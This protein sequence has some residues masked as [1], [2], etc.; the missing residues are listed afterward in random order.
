MKNYIPLHLHSHFSLLDGLSKPE[1]IRQRIDELEMDGCALTDHGVIAGAIPFLKAMSGKK[2][3]ILGNE[4]YISQ[5]SAKVKEDANRK[6]SHLPLLAKNDAGWK[7][8]V[9]ITSAGNLPEHF[10]YKPR[11]SLEEL[12]EYIDGNI[13]CFSGHLG[14]DIANR[15]LNPDDTV[16]PDAI[17]DASNLARW[18][19]EV[20]GDNF[21]LEVQRMEYATNKAQQI[22]SDIVREV[23]IQTG[24]PCIATPDAHYASQ[25]DAI[26]QRIVLCTGLQTT[27]EKANRPDFLLN[28]FFK[29]NNFHIP[30]Y[31]DMISYGHTEEELDNTLEL[32]DRCITYQQVLRTPSIPHF[33]CPNGLSDVQYLRKICTDGLHRYNIDDQ[34]HRE[35]LEMEFRVLEEANLCSYF[36][37]VRD[38]LQFAQNNGWLVGPGRGSSGGCLVSYTADIVKLDPL[39]YNLLFERFYN[40]SRKGSLPDIDVDVPA[41]KRDLI[42]DYIKNKYGHKNV[43][44]M[45][46]F[47][48]MKGRGALKDVFRAYGDISFEEQ[49]RITKFIPD[50][51]K[52]A[53]DLQ[54]MK[55]DT[56]E[57]S[58]IRWAL[59]NNSKQL[60]E[61][62]YLDDNGELHGELADR[63][64]QA[65]RLEGTKTTQSKHAAGVVIGD[66]PLSEICP[67]IYDTKTDSN[68]A[69]FEMNELE[70]V[71][72]VKYDILGLSLLDKV[73]CVQDILM[74][75]DSDD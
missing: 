14:S 75:R 64:A 34:E 12:A 41:G 72:L 43:A 73:M 1:R 38:I 51:S 18:F 62:C 6:L 61:W 54:E 23:S 25:E 49:N 26:D 15:I 31:Q 40:A 11:L 68:I 24:I 52:I 44:Q 35:R 56:G 67:M 28:G 33:K 27:L 32:A 30:S 63:F 10:Y 39:K 16:N 22:V 55:E 59:E 71:G 8:L 65:M 45:V 7:T 20:F 50:E 42:I 74:G 46:S 19:K 69:G 17:R 4:F 3:I 53:D 36:L 66:L 13:I 70:A 29:S 21:R 57:S 37:I 58:I 9:K 48:T 2:R 5:Q 60:A 47:Q